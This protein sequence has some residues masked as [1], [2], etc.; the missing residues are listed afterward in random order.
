MVEAGL[1]TPVK[2]MGSIITGHAYSTKIARG[3]EK[4][5]TLSN[6]SI[7]IYLLGFLF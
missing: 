3:H 6:L 5:K 7:F 1:I 2:V 4:S